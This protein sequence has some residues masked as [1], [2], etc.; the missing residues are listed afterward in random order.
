MTQVSRGPSSTGFLFLKMAFISHF[1]VIVLKSIAL[2]YAFMLLKE[3]INFSSESF[4]ILFFQFKN[5]AHHGKLSKRHHPQR[6][7]D[8]NYLIATDHGPRKKKIY[9]LIT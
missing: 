7:K 4:P 6:T 5:Q 3:G 2:C 9:L 1:L 8:A